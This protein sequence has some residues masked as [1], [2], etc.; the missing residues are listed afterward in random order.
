VSEV[1]VFRGDARVTVS[2]VA[3][4]VRDVSV[5]MNADIERGYFAYR[6]LIAPSDDR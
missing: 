3:L 4:S 1:S 6:G 2:D 5:M